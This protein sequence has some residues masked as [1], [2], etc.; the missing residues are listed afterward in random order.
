VRIAHDPFWVQVQGGIVT[1]AR[2][3]EYRAP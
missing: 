1:S 2:E 3:Q